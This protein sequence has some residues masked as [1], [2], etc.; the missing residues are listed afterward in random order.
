[1]QQLAGLGAL[2]G[3]QQ[4]FAQQQIG[5]SRQ[6]SLQALNQFVDQQ[7]ILSRP[8]EENLNVADQLTNVI[9]ENSL[10]VNAVS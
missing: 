1:M 4:Q 6:L 5:R 3:D 7:A 10:I 2:G 8:G 9:G